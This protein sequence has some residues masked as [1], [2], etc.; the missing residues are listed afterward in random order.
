MNK[1]I[2]SAAVALFAVVAI[3]SSISAS[4]ESFQA[5]ATSQ[6]QVAESSQ[7]LFD[8]FDPI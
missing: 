6:Y 4:P 2:V 1:V 8:R 3:V 5:S 7:A